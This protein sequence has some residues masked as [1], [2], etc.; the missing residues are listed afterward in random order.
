MDTILSVPTRLGIIK[1]KFKGRA[2][3]GA[4]RGE[5]LTDFVTNEA[6]PIES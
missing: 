3:L 2:L 4:L 6:W 1:S 5:L